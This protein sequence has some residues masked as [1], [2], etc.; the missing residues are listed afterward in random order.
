MSEVSHHLTCL[1]HSVTMTQPMTSDLSDE[2][3]PFRQETVEIIVVTV[4]EFCTQASCQSTDISHLLELVL[5]LGE[6]SPQVSIA[7]MYYT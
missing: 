2:S 1:M 5:K 6:F 7:V 3:S 4:L